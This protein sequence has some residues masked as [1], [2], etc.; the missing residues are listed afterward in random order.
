MTETLLKLVMQQAVEYPLYQ[1]QTVT[2]YNVETINKDSIAGFD[3]YDG[4]T[5]IIPFLEEN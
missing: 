4:F 3:N 5:Y 2:I 1:L